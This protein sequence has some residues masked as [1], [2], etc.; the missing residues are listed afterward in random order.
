[1]NNKVWRCLLALVCG[2]V[3]AGCGGGG[4]SDNSGG[5]S[6][7][8]TT[9]TSN[10]LPVV[11]DAGPAALAAAGLRSANGLYASVTI[12]TPGSTT[13]CQTIDHMLVDTGSSGV[14]VLA[15]ALVGTAQP[16]AAIDPASGAPLR[17]CAQFADGY[18]WGSVGLFDVSLGGRLISGLPV[19]IIGDAGSGAA[20]TDCAVGP[21][22]NTVT[23]FGANGILGIGNFLE[24][25]G[26]AC[27][28]QA[29]PGTYYA[30]SGVGG[31]TTCTPTMVAQTRQ[32]ANPVAAL[33]Q[34][35]NGVLISLPAVASPGTA[36]ATGSLYFGVATQANNTPATARWFTLDTHGT[37]TTQHGGTAYGA[38][39]IDSGSNAYFFNDTALPTCSNASYFYCPVNA[40]G[41]ANSVATSAVISGR[42]GV[43]ANVAFQVDNAASL[44]ATQNAVLP[45]LAGPIGT[46]N[47]S[48]TSAFDWGLPFFYGRP[49]YVLFEGRSSSASSTM[50]P[51]VAF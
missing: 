19:Q 28:A 10:V 36:S 33:A 25:C 32:V 38:S 46:L 1:M 22:E 34:D 13:A 3:L 37:L 49:V 44:M 29:I 11:V 43:T 14:R 21:E 5:V 48:G 39:F 6:G 4:S 47:L 2:L 31:T 8:G 12:C 16:A 24:D 35:N 23:S 42:N 30:C 45:G 41:A 51:A 26:A 15:A 7:G 17:E 27:A 50:G 18:S 20:P 40:A 9:T